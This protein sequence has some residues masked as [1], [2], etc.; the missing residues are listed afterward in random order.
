MFWPGPCGRTAVDADLGPWGGDTRGCR[1]RGVA[2]FH[3]VSPMSVSEVSK[4]GRVERR[5]FR[6]Q[7]RWVGV[8]WAFCLL[9]KG[10]LGLYS[11]A[12]VPL[13]WASTR[14]EITSRAVPRIRASVVKKQVNWDQDRLDKRAC[15]VSDAVGESTERHGEPGEAMVVLWVGGWNAAGQKPRGSWHGNR[16][17]HAC[18]RRPRIYRDTEAPE[19]TSDATPSGLCSVSAGR[20]RLAVTDTGIP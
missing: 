19:Y 7:S 4:E 3:R 20:S 18:R 9:G 5:C 15:G 12:C 14:L 11:R 17:H 6:V 10:D 1:G 2:G 8:R 16:I 13:H